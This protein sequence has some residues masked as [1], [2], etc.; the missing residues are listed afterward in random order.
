MKIAVI[1]GQGGGIGKALIGKLSEIFKDKKDVEIIAYGT[2]SAATLAMAK[3]GA[4]RFATGENAIVVGAKSANVIAGPVGIL[5]ANS[6]MGECTP[7]MARAIGES[8]A[9]KVLIPVNKC[10]IRVAGV[11]DAPVFE[12]VD[13]AAKIIGEIYAER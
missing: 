4:G 7:K 13:A 1:D 12:H 10:H 8:D 11:K 5:A 2:N 9:Q 3:A 6:L